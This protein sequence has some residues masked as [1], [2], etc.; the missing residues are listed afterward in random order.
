MQ[1][2][3][4]FIGKLALVLVACFS[5]T[6][7]GVS[8]TLVVRRHQWDEELKSARE[9]TGKLLRARELEIMELRELLQESKAGQRP[10]AWEPSTTK[11]GTKVLLGPHKTIAV[12]QAKKELDRMDQDNGKLFAQMTSARIEIQGLVAKIAQ[13][14]QQLQEAFTVQRDLRIKIE[15]TDNGFRNRVEAARQTTQEVQKTSKRSSGPCATPSCYL[16]RWKDATSS[17][18]A[19]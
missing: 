18:C 19:G 4:T 6:A 15:Q 13:L 8:L 16:P 11:S 10:L 7:V 9:H 1:Q 3:F 12:A 5:I 17:Y 14:R 2:F